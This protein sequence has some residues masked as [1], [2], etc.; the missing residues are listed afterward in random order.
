MH[1]VFEPMPKIQ[2]PVARLCAY[3]NGM[4]AE[5]SRDIAIEVSPWET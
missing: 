2:P 4:I 1:K 3:T 5:T